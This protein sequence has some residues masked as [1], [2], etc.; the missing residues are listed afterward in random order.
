MG[1]AAPEVLSL[2]T[3]NDRGEQL[4]FC[5]LEK[6]RGQRL[7]D[8]LSLPR[9]TLRSVVHELGEQISRMHAIGARRPRDAARFFE[10]DTD[11]FLA[12]EAE[13]V[14]L[15]ADAGLERRALE[16]A[17]RFFERGDGRAGAAAAPPD[18][19]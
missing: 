9:A 6:L 5:F 2:Q 10:T 8:S 1:I 14:E 4:E 16:R 18:A 11:D 3:L 12:M 15:G 17:F 7:S 19:Q 13:F